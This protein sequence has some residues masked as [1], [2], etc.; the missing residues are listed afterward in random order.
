MG[1]DGNKGGGSHT[2]VVTED[3]TVTFG[4]TLSKTFATFSTSYTRISMRSTTT[5]IIEI[6]ISKEINDNP[7]IDGARIVE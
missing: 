1:D 2:D 5:I 4:T 7:S 3:F 6:K